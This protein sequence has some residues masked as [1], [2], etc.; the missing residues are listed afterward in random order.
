MNHRD[1]ETKL[2]MEYI[3]NI[4]EDQKFQKMVKMND[5]SNDFEPGHQISCVDTEGGFGQS[6]T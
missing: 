1:H 6:D 4:P 5:F 3:L 2:S